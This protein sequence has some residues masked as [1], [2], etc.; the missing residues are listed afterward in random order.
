LKC[1][2][3]AMADTCRLRWRCLSWGTF[4]GGRR[5]GAPSL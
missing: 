3:L 1:R 4:C 2:W 5:R